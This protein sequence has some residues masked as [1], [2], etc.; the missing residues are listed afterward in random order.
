MR[1]SGSP[2]PRSKLIERFNP[3]LTLVYLPHLDYCL[4]RTGTEPDLIAK[5]L[6]ELD[7][8]CGK[9]I[10]HFSGRGANHHPVGVRRHAGFPAGSSESRPARDGL[11]TVRDELG[12]EVLDAGESA[13][14]AVA[15][16]QVAHVYVNDLSSSIEVRRCW[17]QRPASKRPR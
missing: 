17:N 14:F 9:L 12:H 3:T 10:D 16:H 2:T 13:A 6:G 1:R 5:D 8:V 4:Q 11:I 7:A 15:D